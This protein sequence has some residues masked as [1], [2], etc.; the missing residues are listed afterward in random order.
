VRNTAD[1]VGRGCG[2]ARRQRCALVGRCA[3]RSLA[4]TGALSYRAATAA[5]PSCPLPQ[6][7]RCQHGAAARSP[8]FT[9]IGPNRGRRGPDRPPADGPDPVL[10]AAQRSARLPTCVEQNSA[11]GA[12][13]M[14]TPA[15]WLRCHC[16]VGVCV[17]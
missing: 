1:R 8:Y 2:R 9:Q 6:S 17:F 3:C 10:G 4:P 12:L 13:V 15:G 11:D 14:A 7:R 5:R 16:V